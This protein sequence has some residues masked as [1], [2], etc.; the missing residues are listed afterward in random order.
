MNL[1]CLKM[2]LWHTAIQNLLI[3][4][5]N[6]RALLINGQLCTLPSRHYKGLYCIWYYF[7]LPMSLFIVNCTICLNFLHVIKHMS[8]NLIVRSNDRE[9]DVIQTYVS[10]NGHEPEQHEVINLQR[11]CYSVQFTETEWVFVRG[12]LLFL[13]PNLHFLQIFIIN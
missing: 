3:P 4:S 2:E 9:I 11:L 1:C 5:Y 7:I 12:Q 10:C 13:C 6:E 8:S